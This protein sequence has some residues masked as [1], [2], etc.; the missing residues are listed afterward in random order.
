MHRLH[1][2][3]GIHRLLHHYLVFST[4]PHIHFHKPVS[5]HYKINSPPFRMFLPSSYI[6][7]F[8]KSCQ[9]IEILTDDNSIRNFSTLNY[10]FTFS[11]LGRGIGSQC[12]NKF[13]IPLIPVNGDT[14][15]Q[16]PAKSAVFIATDHPVVAIKA[17]VSSPPSEVKT[18]RV[19]SVEG[20]VM[21]GISGTGATG[22]SPVSEQAT[23][24]NK[25]IKYRN[26]K[27]KLIFFIFPTIIP[28]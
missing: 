2:K 4:S 6:T 16:S 3:I 9:I 15:N 17:R 5:H 11:I 26:T 27:R 19:F 20:I 14:A 21:E 7:I 8:R 24:N 18:S 1:R 22:S 10:H 13:I 23:T 12:N 25:V 28:D